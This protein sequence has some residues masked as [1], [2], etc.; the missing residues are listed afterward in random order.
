MNYPV[1]QPNIDA[2][3]TREHHAHRVKLYQMFSMEEKGFHKYMDLA[4]QIPEYEEQFVVLAKTEFDEA[5]KILE[6]YQDM[7]QY[8]YSGG[9]SI[10]DTMNKGIEKMEQRFQEY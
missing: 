1:T 6:I 4:K 7:H 9:G 8:D 3:K 10:M 2:E 5:E